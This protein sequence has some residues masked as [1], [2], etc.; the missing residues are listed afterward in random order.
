MSSFNE[1]HKKMS[2]AIVAHLSLNTGDIVANTGDTFRFKKLL[3][4]KEGTW[5][6][7]WKIRRECG[8]GYTY[9]E[10]VG[11]M[12]YLESRRLTR[13]INKLKRDKDG[14]EALLMMQQEQERIK[15]VL[16]EFGFGGVDE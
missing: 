1:N 8:G 4:N 16:K 12:T 10:N 13:L 3:F 5:F 7:C 15:S 2:M 14:E 9:T 11:T 6:P